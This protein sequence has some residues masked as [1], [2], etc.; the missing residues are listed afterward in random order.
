MKKNISYTINCLF[1]P[2]L[3]TQILMQKFDYFQEILK[4]KHILNKYLFI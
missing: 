4:N 3:Q 2:F 1:F